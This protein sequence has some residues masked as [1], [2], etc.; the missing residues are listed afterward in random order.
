MKKKDILEIISPITIA[1]LISMICL[2]ILD[3]ISMNEN[4]PC[5]CGEHCENND[6]NYSFFLLLSFIVILIP[7]IYQLLIGN[8]ILKFNSNKIILNILN[9]FVFAVFFV[10][11]TIAMEFINAKRIDSDLTLVVFIVM[12]FFSLFIF[13]VKIVIEKYIK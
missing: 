1:T 2:Y 12:F 4:P 9:S 13:I 7:S 10:L 11:F 5:E 3:G 8:W 6:S